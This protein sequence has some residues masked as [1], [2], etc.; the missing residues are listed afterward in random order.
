MKT[1]NINTSGKQ[2]KHF[3]QRAKLTQI[4]LELRINASFGSISRIENGVTN[5]TKE[6]LLLIAMA[7][8]LNS[9][10][11]ATLF[12]IEIEVPRHAN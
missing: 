10:E 8:G 12:G 5:P 1:C 9:I 3:R 11:T 7:L 4:E 6:T 2:I